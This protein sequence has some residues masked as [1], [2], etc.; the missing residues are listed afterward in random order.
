MF[1]VCG[2]TLV[3]LCC[4]QY[5]AMLSFTQDR[6]RRYPIVVRSK[7][8]ETQNKALLKL[9]ERTSRP[10]SEVIRDAIQAALDTANLAS[11]A[12]ESGE[13]ETCL[14]L[15]QTMRTEAL[16]IYSCLLPEGAFDLKGISRE[17]EELAA[18]DLSAFRARAEQRAILRRSLA[19]GG[20]A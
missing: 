8:S 14:E 3:V 6:M 12:R 1:I 19:K 2:S 11:N 20:S 16:T 13:T 15:L 18:A 10:I 7:I 5:N 9:S 17:A 4:N